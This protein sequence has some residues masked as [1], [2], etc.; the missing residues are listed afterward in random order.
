MNNAKHTPFKMPLTHNYGYGNFGVWQSNNSNAKGMVNQRHTSMSYLAGKVRDRRGGVADYAGQRKL[1]DNL[2]ESNQRRSLHMAGNALVAEKKSRGSSLLT[3]FAGT[4]KR[5]ESRSDG[6]GVFINGSKRTDTPRTIIGFY[7]IT[8]TA[9][10]VNSA[11]AR[12]KVK[13]C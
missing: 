11:N 1:K 8:A 3:M 13:P 2:R 7:A 10:G 4:G 5:T 6:D 9:L 12:M